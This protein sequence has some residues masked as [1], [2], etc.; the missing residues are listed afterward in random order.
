M[1]FDTVFPNC[2]RNDN[3]WRYIYGVLSSTLRE[4]GPDTAYAVCISV[5]L[6]F[7][8]MVSV[9]S[10]YP[11]MVMLPK[12]LNV[13]ALVLD[14]T[15]LCA[16]MDAALS[17]RAAYCDV[18]MIRLLLIHGI[19]ADLSGSPGAVIVGRQSVNDLLDFTVICCTFP[20]NHSIYIMRHIGV[21]YKCSGPRPPDTLSRFWLGWR[22]HAR[23]GKQLFVKS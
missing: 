8:Y 21:F 1:I 14:R 12:H 19:R 15:L 5:S 10:C 7:P 4:I 2:Y 13:K 22:H 6:C 11:Y 17:Q 18:T 20:W 23:T 16:D 9:F 3:F